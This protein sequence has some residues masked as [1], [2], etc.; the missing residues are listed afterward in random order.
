MDRLRNK[1]RK[2]ESERHELKLRLEKLQESEKTW[3]S[4]KERLNKL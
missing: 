4:E 1:R 3:Q 2:E